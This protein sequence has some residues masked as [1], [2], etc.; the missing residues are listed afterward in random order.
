MPTKTKRKKPATHGGARK[1]AGRPAEVKDACTVSIVLR[2]DQVA[3]LDAAA[4]TSGASR[5]SLIR[6][7]IDGAAL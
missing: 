5:S 7:A 3:K 4:A 1:G 6:D 2:A